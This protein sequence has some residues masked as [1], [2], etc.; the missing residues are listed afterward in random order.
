MSDVAHL[1]IGPAEHGV[2]RHA[3]LIARACG[4][5]IIR[6]ACAADLRSLGRPGVVH[7]PFTERLLGPTLEA[8]DRAFARVRDLVAG[9]GA[10]LSLTLHDV[11]YDDSPLQLRRRELYRRAMASARGVV[12]NSRLELS[13]VQDM[14]RDVHSLRLAPLPIEELT[15]EVRA[16]A[17]RAG[18]AGRGPGGRARR[19]SASSIPTGGTRT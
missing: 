10:G 19:C 4:Q 17:R 9:A 1:I 13:L 11:P 2:T 6:A 7:L 14:A 12:V 18:G 8:A 3:E 16:A 5:E 15:P